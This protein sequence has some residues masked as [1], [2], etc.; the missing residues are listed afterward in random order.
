MSGHVYYRFKSQKEPLRITFDGVGI[1]VFDLKREIILN[2]KLGKGSEFDFALFS[3]DG[4]DG[5]LRAALTLTV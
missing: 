1:S 2:S 5:G 4:Q 3:A